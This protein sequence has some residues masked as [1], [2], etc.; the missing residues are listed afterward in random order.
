MKLS[1]SKYC[2]HSIAPILN[3][4]TRRGISRY[5]FSSPG[6][7]LESTKC[8]N[9]PS[10][11]TPAK[12]SSWIKK[13][14]PLDSKII[15]LVSAQR[16]GKH[17]SWQELPHISPFTLGESAGRLPKKYTWKVRNTQMTWHTQGNLPL[18]SICSLRFL[19]TR[20][21]DMYFLIHVNRYQSAL[22]T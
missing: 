8:R 5:G 4:W 6:N 12:K 22:Q 1:I 11:C 14:T 9:S 13:L 17:F 19:R 3:I 10:S 16:M 15:I 21:Y 20:A 18:L 2:N 7:Y